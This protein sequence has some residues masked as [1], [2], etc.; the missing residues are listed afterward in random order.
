L[1]KSPTNEIATVATVWLVDSRTVSDEKLVP[2]VCWLA[3]D[4]ME[5]YRRFIRPERQRQ[6]LIGRILLRQALGT[7]LGISPETVS[8]VERPGH[9]PLLNCLE[10]V[11]GF[12]LSHSGGWIACA[13]SGQTALGLDIEVMNPERDL[14]ALS[15]QAFD[16][17][18]SALIRAQRESDRVSMFY[19]LWSKKEAAYKL[20]STTGN[21]SDKHYLVLP[22]PDISIVLCSGELLGA[23][24][25][26]QCHE[27]PI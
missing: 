21:D 23:A 10:P 22:H 13:V 24:T 12:S 27:W 7:L 5:R 4:E 20:A 6:F 15:E 1:S 11:P 9:A 19:E 2:F 18:E 25:I 14:M 16:A 26:Q 3:T 17:D 8:L